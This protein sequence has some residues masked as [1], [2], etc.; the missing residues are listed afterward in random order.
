MTV[1]IS[2]NIS[3]S[4]MT[5]NANNY[6]ALTQQTHTNFSQNNIISSKEFSELPIPKTHDS[7]TSRNQRQTEIPTTFE[8]EVHQLFQ[9][10]LDDLGALL[11]DFLPQLKALQ[12]DASKKFKIISFLAQFEN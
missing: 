5:K 7:N 11:K 12:T 6:P 4:N 2:S 3:F 9:R 1:F 10:S 8:G